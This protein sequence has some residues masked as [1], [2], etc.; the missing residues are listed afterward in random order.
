M[1]VGIISTSILRDK[2][3]KRDVK[4]ISKAPSEIQ[5]ALYKETLIDLE[6]YLDTGDLG[7]LTEKSL[8]VIR[9]DILEIIKGFRSLSSRL[10]TGTVNSIDGILENLRDARDNIQNAIDF[11]K[12]GKRE[13]FYL[14]LRLARENIAEALRL[15]RP[16]SGSRRVV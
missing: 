3:T 9:D 2:A 13:K 7:K 8:G 16:I 14:K 4:N 6:D 5:I 15:F 1:I 11:F 10:L 12:Q